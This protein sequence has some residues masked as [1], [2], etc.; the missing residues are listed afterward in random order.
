[1]S[2]EFRGKLRLETDE[3]WLSAKIHFTPILRSDENHSLESLRELLSSAG[4]VF[5]INEEKL[6]E[7]AKEFSEAMEPYLSDVVAQ[8]IP[9]QAGKGK[10]YDFSVFKYPENLENVA[11]KIRSINKAPLIYKTI[12]VKVQQDKRVKS[13][14]LF[15]GGKEKIIT[16]EEERDKKVR[17]DVSSELKDLG[18]FRK[19]EVLCRI[20]SSTSGE[21]T[22][23]KDLK[24]NDLQPP[25]VI[26][27][28]FWTG[29][30]VLNEKNEMIA[31]ETGFARKGKDWVDIIPFED[32][33]WKVRISDNKADCF[34]DIVAGNESAP[35]PLVKDVKKAI[36]ET[37]FPAA[38]L[39]GDKRIEQLL[40]EGCRSGGAQSYSL[41]GD[42]DGSFD[43]EINS[44]AT[45]AQLHL[46][47][48]SG[49]GKPLNLKQA[50]ARV[51]DL[52][53]AGLEA[54]RIREEILNFHGS[55]EKEMTILLAQGSDPR[56]GDD[57]D[58]VVEAEYVS[59]EECAQIRERLA[60]DRLHSF[61]EYPPEKIEKMAHVK[62]GM[63]LFHL[64]Q[65]KGGKDG[66]D[67]FGNVIKGIEGND[68][69]LNVYE[70]IIMQDGVASSKIDGI[71][72][73]S[74][75]EHVYSLR[76]REHQDARIIVSLSE[77]NMSATVSFLPPQGSG[78]PVNGE[79]IREALAEKGVVKG[80]KN[81]VIE[82]LSRQASEGKI[83]T[84]YTVAEGKIPFQGEQN[85][86]FIVDLEPGKKES[87]PVEKG[88][89]IAELSKAVDDATGYNVLGEQLF[90]E[91]AGG[92]ERDRN[93][94]ESEEEG[95]IILKAGVT[96]LL[97]IDNKRLYIKEKQTIRGDLSRSS[98]SVKF[99]GSIAISGSVLSGIF[100]NAGRDLTVME[101]VEA[102]LLSAGGNIMIGKGVKGDR[103]AVLRAGENISLGFAENTN[104]MVN[105]VLKMKKALMNCVVKCN[106]KIQSDSDKTRIIGGSIKVRNGLSTGSIGSEREA[107]THI[108]FGQDYLVEDQI[109]VVA[110]EID[111][112]NEQLPEIDMQ[113][114]NAE[115]KGQQK[116]LMALRKKKVQMLKIL[117]KKGIKSFFLKEKFE[118][119]HESEI[120]IKDTIYPGVS[121]E[122]HGRTF[123][124]KE[125]MTSVIVYFDSST[126][127]I[128][129]KPL[130]S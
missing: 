7:A 35:P 43:I 69:I 44:L 88:D 65:Q 66:K 90:K 15:K 31:D 59:D 22:I 4:I 61:R 80:I 75:E 27:G 67:I 26:E 13:K 19:G 24:G 58:I 96:G 128:K 79:R 37:G 127:K 38:D 2:Y 122:S 126:G 118:I 105:G 101:V 8:G 114:K 84:D 63:K 123:E 56:R 30:H 49:R 77:G 129:T 14:G 60:A 1:M 70:N 28:E 76:V 25:K 112:I 85:L 5:G 111:S 117:E 6:E 32:H 91:E 108:S 23:G 62:K 21:E 106:G 72:D 45:E 110:R 10:T 103:K 125:K 97:C 50:W 115:E 119:H 113:L 102:S 95:K 93:V 73:Y 52:K 17:V 57:R 64:G 41:S 121:F 116:R 20:S 99:P 29:K 16:V 124:V 83:V 78:L 39:V 12:K 81:D 42:K 55:P 94:L 74:C 100:V 36:E 18:F 11:L 98:G 9:P 54:E 71:L 51:L 48:G 109:N 130:V 47:K 40:R 82:E 89:S 46:V 107:K 104:I 34:I 120:R 87:V 33:S 68:P 3:R 86:K 92:I 53:I